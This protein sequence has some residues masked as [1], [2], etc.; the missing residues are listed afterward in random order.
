MTEKLNGAARET[1]L[2]T[3]TQAGWTHDPARDAIHK[4][5]KFK[6]F[7]RAFGFMTQTALIAEKMNHHPEWSNI[8]GTVDVTLITHDVS[9]LSPLD[10]SMAQQLDRLQ[11]A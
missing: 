1:A 11:I 8:Y 5:F 4:T 6:S 3:L 2:E 10:V 9:G 7:V